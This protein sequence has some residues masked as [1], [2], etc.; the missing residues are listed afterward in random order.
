MTPDLE[1]PSSE[2]PP[3]VA[4]SNCGNSAAGKFCPEC[5]RKITTAATSFKDLVVE[6]AEELGGFERRL[7]RTLLPLLFR[8]GFLTREYR[9]GRGS[10]FISPVRSYLLSSALYFALLLGAGAAGTTGLGLLSS[11]LGVSVTWIIFFAVPIFAFVLFVGYY[12]P[13]RSYAEYLIFALFFQT[14]LFLFALPTSL[15]PSAELRTWTRL[16]YALFHIAVGSH[17]LWDEPW[18]KAVMRAGF[19]LAI[20][21]FA[22]VVSGALVGFITTFIV[23]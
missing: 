17:Q 21:G 14:A 20:Y 2:G 16:A 7:F 6:A 9:E 1:K 10:R 22:L 23:P 11:A 4:C 18:F 13:G 8:P 19:A 5:G 3:V 15:L 12:A